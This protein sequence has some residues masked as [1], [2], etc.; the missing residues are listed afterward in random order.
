MLTE[1][2][3]YEPRVAVDICRNLGITKKEFY[4]EFPDTE[5][6]VSEVFNQLVEELGEVFAPVEE[7]DLPAW[8]KVDTFIEAGVDYFLGHKEWVHLTQQI[9]PAISGV[10]YVMGLGEKVLAPLAGAI[11]QGE[12][13]GTMKAFDNV[14][15]PFLLVSMMSEFCNLVIVLDL[16]VERDQI[17]SAI[18]DFFRRALAP[19]EVEE[20]LSGA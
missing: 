2:G 12:S 4:S 15:V 13:E 6:L 8:R 19:V 9:S 20:I 16:P 14:M 17:V 11:E 7:S 18:K 1:S 5:L 10:K 3:Y